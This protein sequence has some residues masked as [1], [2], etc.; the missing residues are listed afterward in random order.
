MEQKLGP[1]IFPSAAILSTT[2][3]EYTQPVGLEYFG[4]HHIPL[5]IGSFLT[6]FSHELMSEPHL[7]H[8]F[9]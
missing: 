5:I 9:A 2:S 6:K 4:T 1:D 8:Q 7:H 3:S